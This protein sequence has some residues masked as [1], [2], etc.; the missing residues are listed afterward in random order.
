MEM[1]LSCDHRGTDGATA[2]EFLRELKDLLEEPG[3]A[4]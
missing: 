2:S 4:L 1:T 3:L